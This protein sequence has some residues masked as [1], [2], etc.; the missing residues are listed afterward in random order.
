MHQTI[1]VPLITVT[2]YDYPVRSQD[3]PFAELYA[4]CKYVIYING[5]A[6]RAFVDNIDMQMYVHSLIFDLGICT[7]EKYKELFSES[8]TFQDWL[9]WYYSVFP[10][11]K[12][13]R[14][15]VSYDIDKSNFTKECMPIK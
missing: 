4:R 6:H 10:N 1:P 15:V 8:L 5:R 9:D 13:Q 12:I 11:G 7:R 3:E 14:C 2:E